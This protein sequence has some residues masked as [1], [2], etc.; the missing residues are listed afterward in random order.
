MQRRLDR[1]AA[2]RSDL[3]VKTVADE[4]LVY[5]LERHRAHRLNGAAAAVWRLCDGTRTVPEI[6]VAA[7]DLGTP[8]TAEA[9]DY[10][11]AGLGRARLLTA[12]VT[13]AALTRREL[14]QRL[15]TAAALPLV[16]SLVA[17]TAAQAQSCLPSGALCSPSAGVP[18][19]E[20][21]SGTICENCAS[22][23]AL[24]TAF[25]PVDPAETLAQVV[26]LPIETWSYRGEAVRHLGPMAQDFAAFGLG[27]DDRHISPIDASGVA[28]SALQGLHA[29]VA[30]QAARLAAL[31]GECAGL[32]AELDRRRAEPAPPPGPAVTPA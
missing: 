4:V 14:V 7:R 28:L 5:D 10:A 19:C 16:A 22:D 25:A 26:A 8:V 15:G 24:K 31:E 23:R 2:R 30:A 32:R 11:L 13:T 3:V 17:P 12:P 9:V 6:T 18:C 1:P 27:A 21:C 29:V 20:C